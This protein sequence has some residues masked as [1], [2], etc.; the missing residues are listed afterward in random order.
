MK[1]EVLTLTA[2]ASNKRAIRVY[3]KAGF[4]R[5]GM[6]PK[7]HFKDGRYIDEFIM[8]NLLS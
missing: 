6:I 2:F 8:T 1:L 5:T 7:K 4:V 3:E